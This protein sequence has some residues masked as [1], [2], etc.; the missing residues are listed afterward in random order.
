MTQDDK[1]I[2]VREPKDMG[3]MELPDVAQLRAGLE[4][5]RKFQGVVR[6]LLIE[7][8]DWGVIPGTPKPTLLKPGA[9][10]IAKILGLADTYE[11]VSET[12]NWAK[13]FFAYKI[14]CIL[15]RFGTESILATGIGECN[16]METKY[17]WRWAWPQDVPDQ[18]K[19]G[20]VSRTVKG[21]GK[22]YRVEN[23]QIF[24]QVN[25]ILKMAKKRA[26]VDAALSAGRLSDVFTQDIEDFTGAVKDE[27]ESK[28]SQEAPTAPKTPD[29]PKDTGQAEKGAM[30]SRGNCP[31][32]D[33]RFVHRT[34][35]NQR[36]PNKG[37]PYDFWS[38]PQKNEDGTYCQEKPKDEAKEF[39]EWFDE[40]S[41]THEKPSTE[42]NPNPVGKPLQDAL[43]RLAEKLGRKVPDFKTMTS[44]EAATMHTDWA[45]EARR[46]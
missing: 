30:A 45:N 36:G 7:G 37:K 8:S 29:A 6:E 18:Q 27:V 46:L 3:A 35:I 15:S 4:A 22:Q 23:D 2:V 1:A 21:G 43:M 41:P 11:I 34:G 39:E 25:T 31:V 14:R 17:R 10:K 24:D 16:S 32:H 26:L 20:L 13:P 9:E 44:P 40:S 38:C 12:E 33:V 42:A 28:P 5:V 19:G